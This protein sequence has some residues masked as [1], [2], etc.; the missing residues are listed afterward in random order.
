MPNSR[1]F[2]SS[3][4]LPLF[5]LI[6]LGIVLTAIAWGDCLSPL[7]T[8]CFTNG[9]WGDYK[10]HYQGWISYLH[11][12]NW[13]PP[14][15]QTFTW[16]YLSSV[17]FTDSIPL[18][19]ISFKPITRLFAL[20]DWQYFSLLSLFNS[21]VLSWSAF[22]I[23]TVLGWTPLPT[24][25]FGIFLLTS[26]I[27][28]TRLSVHHEALQ[29]H[30]V[31]LIAIVW[32]LSREKSILKWSLLLFCSVGIHAYYL[33]MI[34]VAFVSS[35]SIRKQTLYSMPI[36]LLVIS[37]SF[38]FFGFLPGSLSS[39]S[40][41]W[42]SNIVSLI[43]PQSH[44]LIFPPLR[45]SEPFEVEGYSF[46]GMGLIVGLMLGLSPK[47][48]QSSGRLFPRTWSI[49]AALLFV[50]ALGPTWNVADMPIIPHNALL[51]FPIVPKV[52][53][54]FRSSGRF[55]WPLYYTIL[56]WT[57]NRLATT[58]ASSI[59]FLLITFLHLVD[60]GLRPI[61][62]QNTSYSNLLAS[63]NPVL[64]WTRQNPTLAS[65]FS[66]SSAFLVGQLTDTSVLPPP[67]TPQYLN[68]SII[69][70]W[71][72]SG[73]TR[74]PRSYEPQAALD[75]LLAKL[76]RLPPSATHLP[77]QIPQNHDDYIII[78]TDNRD[79]LDALSSITLTRGISMRVLAPSVF[80]LY[81]TL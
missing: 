11:S 57:V 24:T 70:N 51:Q 13:V 72:G 74:L 6:P 49:G 38:L 79:F 54:I 78:V 3:P 61:Y 5:I 59:I 69:S 28:W 8:Q 67:Y 21:V 7:N 76:T 64:L 34:F 58:A 14:Y 39:G 68:P 43:D 18:A 75:A 31:L 23:G 80:K 19:A 44:S 66:R 62:R 50:F 42:G 47:P 30:G 53:D 37:F 29:L 25:V 48:T 10:F 27:S 55:V 45:K 16:P 73:I 20:P 60:S 9:G 26:P 1:L 12:S 63:P 81:L 56:I 71:G 22:R 33:P 52:Y 2:P 4:I 35:L 77:A 41:V 36:V 15:L 17:M 40:E 46:L 32:V 65:E